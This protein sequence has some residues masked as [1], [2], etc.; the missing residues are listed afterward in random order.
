ML[1]HV[2]HVFPGSGD[3]NRSSLPSG[4]FRPYFEPQTPNSATTYTSTTGFKVGV[5][6]GASPEGPSAEVSAS[7]SKSEA[8]KRTI[9]NFSVRNISDGSMTGWNFYYTAMDGDN[10]K[11]QVNFWG[12]LKALLILR[13]APSL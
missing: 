11:K 9:N 5:M 6:G 10:W 1:I 12:K 4:W 3:V 8:V 7:V 2:I 13:R